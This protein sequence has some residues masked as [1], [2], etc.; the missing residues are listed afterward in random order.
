MVNRKCEKKNPVTT[1]FSGPQYLNR[2]CMV[3]H[4]KMAPLWSQQIGNGKKTPNPMSVIV[5]TSHGSHNKIHKALKPEKV[6]VHATSE[7]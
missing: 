3:K 4:G 1:L 5:L 2:N 6:M 7:R